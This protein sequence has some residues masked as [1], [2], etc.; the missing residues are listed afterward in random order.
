MRNALLILTLIGTPMYAAEPDLSTPQS[1]L[2]SYLIATKE[3]DLAS[4]KLCWTIDDNNASGALDVIVGM[5]ISSR[6]LVAASK[7]KFGTEGIKALGK[8][9]RPHCTDAAIDSTLARI[10]SAEVKERGET[11]RMTIPWEAGEG[12][13]TPVFLYVKAPIF[14]RKIGAEWKLDANTLT[15]TDKAA[16]L[17]G[18]NKIWPIWRDEMSLMDELTGSINKGTIGTLA[19]FEAAIKTRVDGLKAKYEK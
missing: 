13:K 4:A 1:T 9:D 15:G 18:P 2:R 12:E 8:W 10:A 3:N 17:F 11:A 16:D 6:K 5:G 14:V 7:G 19:E